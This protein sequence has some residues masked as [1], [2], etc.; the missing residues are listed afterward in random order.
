MEPS[1]DVDLESLQA[2]KN[3]K[4]KFEK[5]ASDGANG[6][7]QSTPSREHLTVTAPSSPR[8]RATS[9]SQL[10]TP[11]ESFQ[12]RASSSSSDLRTPDSTKTPTKRPPPPPP[13]RGSKV[14]NASAST[15]PV[16]SLLLRPVPPPP[17]STAT[18][19]DAVKLSPPPQR[20]YGTRSSKTCCPSSN[21]PMFAAASFLLHRRVVGTV[22]VQ[23]YPLFLLSKQTLNH[24]CP[25]VHP[26]PTLCQINLMKALSP[27]MKISILVLHRQTRCHPRLLLDIFLTGMALKKHKVFIPD[28]LGLISATLAR[29]QL[30]VTS[31]LPR[32]LNFHRAPTFYLLRGLLPVIA[33]RTPRLIALQN[34]PYCPLHHYMLPKSRVLHHLCLLEEV[35]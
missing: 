1:P 11:A 12:L 21:I 31:V 32:C 27:R 34:R 23:V 13:P 9:S 24:Q 14:V 4:S 18:I 2:V 16:Q 3:L 6:G 8:P 22:L 26:H 15:Q 25:R 28:R 20:T 30:I 33:V 35:R 29:R 10:V 17:V 19:S 5:L 7:I